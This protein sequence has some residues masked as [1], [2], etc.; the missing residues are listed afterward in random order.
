MTYVIKVGKLLWDILWQRCFQ[1]SVVLST[2]VSLSVLLLR[3]CR[4][5][6]ERCGDRRLPHQNA[7]PA[8]IT[9]FDKSIMTSEQAPHQLIP[10]TNI[11]N[12]NK[13]TSIF[14]SS[15]VG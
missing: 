10:M 14:D 2:L 7:N 8:H 3:G 12:D 9:T 11:I 4:G 5:R 15:E 6:E 1:P 13:E